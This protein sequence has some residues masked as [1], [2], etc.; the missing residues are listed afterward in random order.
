MK[1][2]CL[3][4]VRAQDLKDARSVAESLKIPFRILNLADFYRQNVVS[5]MIDGYASG[6][7]PIQMFM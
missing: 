6:I 3:G 2:I 7:T 5:P 4:I 1:R